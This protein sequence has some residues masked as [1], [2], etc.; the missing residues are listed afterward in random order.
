MGQDPE[1]PTA[2][3][4]E[5][6]EVEEQKPVMNGDI[7]MAFQ[8]AQKS[9]GIVI[10]EATNRRLLRKIDLCLCPLMCIVYAIQFMDKLSN[11]YA[12]IMGLREDLNMSGDIY[13]WTGTIFYLAYLLA[14][15]PVSYM[16]QRVSLAKAT[17]VFVIIWGFVL[18]MGAVPNNSPG[19]LVIRALLGVFESAVTPAFVIITSQWYRRQEQF[20]RT[21]MWFS[22][23]GA[24]GL[25]GSAIA[26][27]LLTR[28]ESVGTPLAS[29]RLLLITIG[30]ITIALGVLI[31]LHIPDTPAKAWF[32]SEEEK[33]QVV[34]RIR[35]NKQGFGNKKF[36]KEQAKEA[37]TDIRT[38]VIF[39]AVLAN[40][41]PNG[42]ITNFGS[43]LI[44]GLG[45][46]EANSFLMMMPSNAVQMIS[47]P[48]CGYVAQKTD[49]R[50]LVGLFGATISTLSTCLLAFSSSTGSQLAGYYLFYFT[51]VA[52]V[53]L[54]SCIASNTAGHTKK[55]IVNALSLI[56]YCV[57]NLIGPLTFIESE[58]PQYNTAKIIMVVMCVLCMVLM[59]ALLLI[60][61]SANKRRDKKN[62]RL[63][64]E[65]S[66]FADLTDLQ[67]PEFRYAL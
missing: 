43:I 11:S 41:L 20:L 64:M 62:E 55:V 29:W 30:V 40:N 56:G 34:E 28:E 26:Y 45:Y 48:L 24:G 8:L 17:G 42:G 16:L 15:F 46:T 53:C 52:F 36:S 58:E 18:A 10:D 50:M 1:K 54:L 49:R 51:P 44:N 25:I 23:N 4:V 27:G 2:E 12:S 61:W 57:G 37:F 39:F 38:Y 3:N 33:M 6:A 31:V 60:N 7:D 21:A 19:F 5:H 32:L 66:E 22:M 14:E 63:Y 65:N 35:D 67:N 13:S 47:L 59:A 9:K